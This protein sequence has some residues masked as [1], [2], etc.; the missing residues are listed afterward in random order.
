MRE[1]QAHCWIANDFFTGSRVGGT[2]AVTGTLRN[3]NYRI[4]ETATILFPVRWVI[5]T[6]HCRFPFL[7]A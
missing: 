6:K 4:P 7:K 5:A 1:F 3:T 2:K